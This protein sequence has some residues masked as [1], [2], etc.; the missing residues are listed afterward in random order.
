MKIMSQSA[1][2][3]PLESIQK[4]MHLILGGKVMLGASLAA[5]Y[6]GA[7]GHLNQAVGRHLDRF[8]SDFM[9]Q[10]TAGETRAL[11]FQIG[12]PKGRRSHASCAGLT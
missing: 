11:P 7:T 4:S 3:I 2:T 9:F 1:E 8:P 12:R 6:A 10:L 5:L